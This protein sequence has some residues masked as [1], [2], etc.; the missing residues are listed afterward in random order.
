M[1]HLVACLTENLHPLIPLFT[2]SFDD[3]KRIGPVNRAIE[4]GRS[5]SRSSHFEVWVLCVG[6]GGYICINLRREAKAKSS[7]IIVVE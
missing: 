3:A 2:S 6:G 1:R 5:P 7:Q 4:R